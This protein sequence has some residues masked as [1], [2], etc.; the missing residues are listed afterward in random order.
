[1]RILG[2][3]GRG[4]GGGEGRPEE[5]QEE[6]CPPQHDT[7]AAVEPIDMM[8]VCEVADEPTSCHHHHH[9]HHLDNQQQPALGS[10]GCCKLPLKEVEKG[11]GTDGENGD[12]SSDDEPAGPPIMLDKNESLSDH[13]AD[14]G[15]SGVVEG[16]TSYARGYVSKD[17]GPAPWQMTGGLRPP[18]GIHH[19]HCRAAAAIFGEAA[20]RVSQKGMLQHRKALAVM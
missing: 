16:E 13:W 9:H 8:N 20:H 4:G 6:S 10:S 18:V 1:M 11:P 12:V 19:E 7:A 17:G 15:L 5:E 3:K 14:V 2:E